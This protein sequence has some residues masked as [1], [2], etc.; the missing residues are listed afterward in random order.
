MRTRHPVLARICRGA[1]PVVGRRTPTYLFSA[2]LE[3][4]LGGTVTKKNTRVELKVAEEFNNQNKQQCLCELW[5]RPNDHGA[6]D[7]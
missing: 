2:L 1:L 6:K 4:L 7:K 3:T 5:T